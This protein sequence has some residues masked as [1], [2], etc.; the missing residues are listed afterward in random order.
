MVRMEIFE[1]ISHKKEYYAHFGHFKNVQ[2]RFG[3]FQIE[4]KNSR[5]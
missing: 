5:F 3:D 2:N 1:G 4:S